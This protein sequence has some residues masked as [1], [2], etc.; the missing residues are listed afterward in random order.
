MALTP[1]GP[2]PEF[3]RIRAIAAA[4]GDAAHGLGDDCASLE[5]GW[6][7][8]TDLTVEDV[9]FRRGW[10][11]PRELGWRAA[12]AAL[13]DLAAAGA[14][15]GPVLVALAAPRDEPPTTATEI[16]VGIGEAVTTVGGL[17]VGGDLSTG[18]GL[19]I[20]VTVLGKAERPVGRRGARVGDELWVTGTLGGARA[21][22]QA[23]DSGA[24]PL[25]GARRRFARPMARIAEGRI[26]AE[27][28][29]AMMD[30]SDGLGGDAHHLARASGVG[31][32]IDLDAVPADPAALGPDR[33][34]EAV[35]AGEDYE[36]LA[37]IP[38]GRGAGTAADLLRLTGTVL[39]RIGRV[40]PGDRVRFLRGTADVVV[41]GFDHFR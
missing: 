2:G 7:A 12:M 22:W 5:G 26:L 27:V 9:H 17:I 24:T 13:S 21:A 19:A 28:V 10:L 14:S 40:V 16:M 31:V 25:A 37:A 36:L 1:M 18:P 15:A 35:S 23:W 11:A 39:T 38:A 41:T 20:T 34:I 32:E 4:L 3:D 30:L 8:S 6:R 33:A 29:T